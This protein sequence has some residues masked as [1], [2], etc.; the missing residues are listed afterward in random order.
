MS[1]AHTEA[2]GLCK[3]WHRKDNAKPMNPAVTTLYGV[4]LCQHH[5]ALVDLIKIDAS[6]NRGRSPRVRRPLDGAPQ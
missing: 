5:R 6:P 2:C 3:G 4:R 1:F